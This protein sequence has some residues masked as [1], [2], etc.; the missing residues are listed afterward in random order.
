MDDLKRILAFWHLME[1]PKLVF[2]SA[3][4]SSGREESIAEH[5][6]RMA[7]MAMIMAPKIEKELDIGKTLKMILVHDIG[8]IGEGDI[9]SHIHTFDLSAKNKK[10]QA[11]EQAM[12]SIKNEFPEFGEEIFNL[13]QEY[14]LQDTYEAKF[15]KAL[16]KLDARVQMI[17]DSAT[18][19]FSEE[20]KEK[21]GILARKTSEICSIDKIL[22]ELDKL[23]KKERE[24]KYG[25]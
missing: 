2:R 22:T 24:N 19:E 6:W 8:E 20:K 25:F 23:S 21:S 17:D 18:G 13:W 9:P 11:E 1:K 4:L 5:S 3:K 15:V 14:E 12:T 10:D 7:L 16:D